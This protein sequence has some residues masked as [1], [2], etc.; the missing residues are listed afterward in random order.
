V[1]GAGEVIVQELIPGGGE[2]QLAYCA[3]FRDG[4]A[5]ASMVV[6]RLR[7]H[8]PLFGRASTFVQTIEHPELE[9]V[10]ERLLRRIGYYGLVELEYKHDVRDGQ[11]KLLDINARTW[12]Y[13]SLGQ[14]AGVD[15]PYLLYADQLSLPAPDGA[16]RARRRVVD[17]AGDGRADGRRA[18]G[19]G[20]PGLARV[21]A[22]AAP[23]ERR[24]GV[25]PRRPAAGRGGA[26]AAAVSGGQ[27]GF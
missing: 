2:T 27:A 17:P 9:E 3:F 14:R 18:A 12:G 24:V 6:N 25:Q 5:A 15:F 7:Q 16:A 10:S 26:G 4:R 21:P 20:R 11:T 23:G 19:A 22:L 1:V 13:H 8:P